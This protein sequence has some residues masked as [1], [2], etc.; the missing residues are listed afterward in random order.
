MKRT[1]TFLVGLCVGLMVL[2]VAASASALLITPATMPQLIGSQ[3]SND[4]IEAY[5]D[6][7]IWNFDPKELFSADASGSSTNIEWDAPAYIDTLYL[8][9]KDG[10]HDPA[11][12]LF[13]L[14][15]IDNTDDGISDGVAW[16]RM[17]TLIVSGFWSQGGA[18]SHVAIY[19]GTPVPEPTS[20]LLLGFG[21]VGLAGARRMLRK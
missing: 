5:L 7:V 14:D 6:T 12:Y 17:E 8:V 19:G 15:N 9:V 10:N 18:I 3:T 11:W 13:Y 2:G 16:N 1:K 4:D 21:L 20:L